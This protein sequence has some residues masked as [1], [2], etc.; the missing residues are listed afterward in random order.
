MPVLGLHDHLVGVVAVLVLRVL[1]VRRLPQPERPRGLVDLQALRIGPACN[2][3][4]QLVAFHVGGPHRDHVRAVLLQLHSQLPLLEPRRIV[5]PLQHHLDDHFSQPVHLHRQLLHHALPRSQRLH[6]RVVHPVAPAPFLVDLEAP[7]PAGH[8]RAAR[9]DRQRL[10]LGVVHHQLPA[11]RRTRPVLL[12]PAPIS[13]H[14]PRAVIHPVDVDLQRRAGAEHTVAGA[15]REALAARLGLCVDR[16]AVGRV[17]PLPAHAVQP[18]HAVLALHDQRAA[19]HAGPRQSVAQR[20]GAVSVDGLQR[21]AA[22]AEAVVCG[23]V[24][25]CEGLR[26]GELRCG[27]AHHEVLVGPQ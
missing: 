5:G 21:A 1:V 14:H 3:V 10:P 27:V 16:L 9:L 8:H 6:P 4:A 23:G 25:V 26:C 2:H 20:P 11:G 17:A 19:H 13:C 18:E 7:A 12:Q 24:V 15:H 22:N